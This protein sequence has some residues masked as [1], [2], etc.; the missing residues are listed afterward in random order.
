MHSEDGKDLS[1]VNKRLHGDSSL[2]TVAMTGGP[3]LTGG[4]INT[5]L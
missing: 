5:V 1:L 2:S 4:W 3:T